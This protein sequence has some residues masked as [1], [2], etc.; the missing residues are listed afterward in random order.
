M[1]W[2]F[3]EFSDKHSS[4]VANIR[5]LNIE[6]IPPQ[7]HIICDD[8]FQTVHGSRENDNGGNLQSPS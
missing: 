8:L 1:S 7:Y 3:F 6:Y 5:N 4:L 2:K